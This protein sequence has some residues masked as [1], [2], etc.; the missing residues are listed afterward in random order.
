MC[1]AIKQQA[2]LEQADAHGL[3]FAGLAPGIE[4]RQH[5]IGAEQ[6]GHDVVCRGADAQRPSGWPG[7]VGHAGHHLH[8]LVHGG[9]VLVGAVQEALAGGDDQL[10]VFGA[11][12]LGVVAELAQRDVAE[13]LH[14]HVGAGDELIE[15][16][17]AL[18]A[19]GVEHDRFL[20]AV[21]GGEEGAAHAAQ[22][23]RLVAL[24]R[25][26]LDHLGAE[27]GEEHAAGR[28]HDH[29]GHLDHADPGKGAESRVH[30]RVCS[31]WRQEVTLPV[32]GNNPGRVGYSSAAARNRKGVI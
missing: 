14:E 16:G 27:E 25:L 22:V 31:S 20:A 5:A 12:R 28:A 7:H 23:A 6:A 29:V 19:G 11:Q 17:A 9:A 8:D 24:G 26:D 32:A 2:V 3:A 4:A 30:R 18:G 1:C 21:E 10:G 15:R 13:V